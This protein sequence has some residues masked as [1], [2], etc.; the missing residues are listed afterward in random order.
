LQLSRSTPLESGETSRDAGIR[1]KGELSPRADECRRLA[2]IASEPDDRRFWLMLREG[3][4]CSPD[5]RP[6]LINWPS[7]ER[8]TKLQG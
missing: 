2:E 5:H 7:P 4:S 3:M 6:T 8:D 1:A